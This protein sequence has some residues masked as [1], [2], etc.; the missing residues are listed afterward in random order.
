VRKGERDKLEKKLN[1]QYD[2]APKTVEKYAQLIRNKIQRFGLWAINSLPKDLG[3]ILEENLLFDLF[4][5]KQYLINLRLDGLQDI[6]WPVKIIGFFYPPLRRK[7]E[8][9]LEQAYQ[10]VAADLD[11]NIQ[12]SIEN[13]TSRLELNSN[14][15]EVSAWKT[16]V[17]Y[18]SQV[19]YNILRRVK[20]DLEKSPLRFGLRLE[21]RRQVDK[22][23]K[24]RKILLAKSLVCSPEVS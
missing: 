14:S 21:Y 23:I 20:G 12:A 6:I 2:W 19:V 8:N 15:E 13:F 16:E 24:R 7:H 1:N 18:T 10:I 3:L 4:L 9:C 5:E 17:R 22:I 11:E